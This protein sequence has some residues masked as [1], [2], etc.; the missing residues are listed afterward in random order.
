MKTA[1]IINEFNT[2]DPVREKWIRQLRAQNGPCRII[3]LMSGD[4]TQ[5]GF[6]AVKD[7]YAR[8]AQAIAEGAD[9]VLELPVYSC[10]SSPD[11]YAFA[12]VSLLESLHCID[13]LYLACDTKDTDLL[14]Q[15]AHFLFAE[16]IQYQKTLKNLRLTGMSFYDAQAAAAEKF[17]PGAGQ[18]LKS[19]QNAFAVEY[20]R[21]LMRLYSRTTPCLV[22]GTLKASPD[23]SPE[24][25]GYL[26]TLLNYTLERGPKDLDEISG[27]TAA[28]TDAIRQHQPAYDTFEDFCRRL[29]TPSRSPA[30]IRRYMLSA[31]LNL[32]KSDM[33][34]CRLYSFALYIHILA[35]NTDTKEI[36]QDLKDRT[37]LPMIYQGQPT[38]NALSPA[39]RRMFAFDQ[40]AHVLYGLAFPE[41]KEESKA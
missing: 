31:I 25:L 20:I 40:R 24:T 16:N 4:F 17:I 23:A 34:L 39:A 36:L 28:L 38:D 7:K 3:A 27:G 32:H 12:A 9:M 11:T 30:N 26:T 37:R 29:A 35:I 19:R 21:A 10:L 15:T 6:P 8:A 5:Q 18:I 13:T 14:R 41:R 2:N 1:A 33:A 22:S